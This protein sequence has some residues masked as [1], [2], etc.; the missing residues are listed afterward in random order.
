MQLL[1]CRELGVRDFLHHDGLFRLLPLLTDA[2]T[3]VRDAGYAALEAGCA[4][5]CCRGAMALEGS[6]L[7]LLLD[8]AMAETPAR[9]VVALRLLNS[10]LQVGGVRGLLGGWGCWTGVYTVT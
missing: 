1:V 10:C 2:D 4:F 5:Q 7:P 8:R 9:A 6:V 3:Q